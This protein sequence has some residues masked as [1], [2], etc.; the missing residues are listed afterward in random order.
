MYGISTIPCLNVNSTIF[1]EQ[2]TSISNVLNNT[3]N[4]TKL[5]TSFSALDVAQQK[6]LLSSK[7]LTEEQKVQCATMATLTSANAKYTAEQIAKATGVS[8][9][10]LANLGLIK[11]TD[12]LTISELAEK[13]ASDA[14]AKSVLE[15]I[16]AQNAQA[17]ANGEVTASNVMLATSEGGA[18]LATG[19]FTTAIKANIKAMW[20]WMTTTPVGWITML[21]GGILGAVTAYN[22]LT[23]SVEETK[24]KAE[25]LISTYKTAL[26]TANSHKDSIDNIADRYEE[27]SKGVNNLGE[28][29]SLT[30]EEYQEYNSIVNDI[31]EMF[32]TMV[33]G[34]TDEGNAIL[35]LKGNVD[36]LREAYEAEAQAAYNSLIST[37]KDSDGNDILKD[38]NNVIIGSTLGA[39]DWGN[40]EK[41]DYLDKLMDATDSVDSMLNLWD[42]SLN[43]AYSEWFEDFAGVGGTVNIGKLTDEDL[44][45]IR[46][47]AKILKQQYQAEIDSAVDNAETL[48]NAYLMTNEDY[49]KLDE[50]S[51]NAASIMVNSLNADIVS[52]FGEDKENVGKYVD[53]IVQII[54][55]NPDA[56]DAMI[57]LFTM[58]TTDMPVDDIEYWTNA[59]IDTIAKILQEDPTEL[60]I[61]LGF[62][63][64]TTEPL[65][66]KVQGFLKDEFDGKVGELTLEELDIASKLEI[67]KGT[68]LSWDE[69]I[70]K[71]E[72]F[73]NQNPDE[74]TV[75]SD[76]FSLEDT[77]GEATA[78]GNLNDQIDELQKAYT[79]LKKAMDSYKETGTFTLDQV[80]EIISYG[81]EYLKYLMDENGN[82]QLNEEALNNVAIARINE[83]RVKALSNLMDNLDS[84][85]NEA[86]ALEYLKQQL[87][88]TAEGYDEITE[89]RINAW[90]SNTLESNITDSTRES[91]LASFRNQA[92]AINEMFDNISIGSISNSSTK[93]AEKSAKDYVDSYME[94]MKSSLETN[95]IDFRTYSND[96]SAFLKKMFDEG[97]ISGKEYFDYVQEQLETEKEVK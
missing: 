22:A 86:S 17:V 58:D 81:G 73:K 75:F 43:S 20:T 44:A 55:T 91:L 85:T 60:K 5:L 14:Q 88:D 52:K 46:K 68:L 74:I 18:T 61:R 8:A 96:V 50:Q 84:I 97:K 9:E 19:A 4:T 94:F 71:I 49:A 42:E 69:L 47:N 45:N 70:A 83:M 76:F 36:A 53:D 41:I 77:K 37:G 7:L 28:N 16:I 21:V 3:G 78:L 90:L 95:R 54:S 10:T 59:Y 87:I 40:A 15:K 39:H 6:V 31:A 30:A 33:Q 89:S 62:D 1:K 80:Q 27:L 13:A 34:Y 93:D 65:K 63:N 29:V 38:A 48:A 35:K 57:G 2:L 67:P 66:T 23:D 79:G 64:D 51:K 32:P 12:T 26:D 92:N 56:K 25:D 11:S 72:E 24:E 82:L